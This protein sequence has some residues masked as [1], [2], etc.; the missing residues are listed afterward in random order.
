[1]PAYIVLKAWVQYGLN[2]SALTDPKTTFYQKYYSRTSGDT[3]SIV[4]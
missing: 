3:E 1:L 2:E 4:I